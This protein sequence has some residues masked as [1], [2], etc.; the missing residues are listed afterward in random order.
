MRCWAAVRSASASSA[1]SRVSRAPVLGD[2]S[3]TIAHHSSRLAARPRERYVLHGLDPETCRLED[4]GDP[5]LGREPERAGRVR[6]GALDEPERERR[7]VPWPSSSR[8][9]RVG[10]DGERRTAPPDGAPDGS[11]AAAASMSGT[12]ISPQRQSDAVER[13]VGER[14]RRRVLD[15][16]LD[17]PRG[18]APRLAVPRR[19]PSPE[20]RPS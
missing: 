1:A 7:C 17:S 15:R 6:V 5:S 11:R 9:L 3:T 20:R 18:R 16:E 14:E 2:M 12:S 13:P 4:R 19:R 8:L 10:P